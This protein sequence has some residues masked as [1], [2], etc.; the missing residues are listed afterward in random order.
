VRLVL[1][2]GFN[3]AL[4]A[5]ALAELATRAGHSVAGV[6]VVN[7][8]SIRRVRQLLRQRG[9]AA[10]RVAAGRLA[11]R[12]PAGSADETMERFLRDQGIQERGL[13]TWCTTRKVPLHV[14]PD[15]D[16]PRAIEV[17]R[18]SGCD[19]VLYAGGGILRKPF[20]EAA[21]RRVLNP[22]SGLLPDIRGMNACEW[23]LLLG[24][25][26]TVTIHYIDEGIDTGAILERIPIEVEP[27][28]TIDVLRAKCVVAGVEGVLRAIPAL[29]QP[30][31]PAMPGSAT[32]RQCFTLAP[33]LREL[34]EARLDRRT[35]VS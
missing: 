31:P 2:A 7:P 3:G 12:P 9:A 5:V 21:G 15:L 13:S 35:A 22:H 26:P 32:H 11:G 27:G 28:D 10:L 20:I 19:G 25:P 4:H 30:I 34:L 33:V 23:S 29:G 14:V 1:T 24:L 16:V 18:A 6:L 8:Y 17:L